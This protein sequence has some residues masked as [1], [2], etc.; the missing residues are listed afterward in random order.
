NGVYAGQF[1]VYAHPDF[2]HYAEEKGLPKLFSPAFNAEGDNGGCV[3]FD[4]LRSEGYQVDVVYAGLDQT[5]ELPKI[6]FVIISH[7]TLA[8]LYM[9]FTGHMRNTIDARVRAREIVHQR[10]LIAQQKR[11]DNPWRKQQQK[12]PPYDFVR[13][14]F[15]VTLNGACTYQME[16]AFLDT[17]GMH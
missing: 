8:E 7:F 11:M 6:Q 3:A 15:A 17:S 9:V 12:R 10:R 1:R 2:H 4:Y 13:L 16:L 14:P 5:R